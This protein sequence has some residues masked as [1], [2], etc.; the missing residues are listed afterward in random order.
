VNR[1]TLIS[2]ISLIFQ[3]LVSANNDSVLVNESTIILDFQQTKELFF[4]FAEGD[5][6]IFDLEMV[7]GKHIKEIEVTELPSN[8]IFSDFKVKEL[9]N[10]RIMI[11]NKGIYTFRFFSS[12]LTRRVCK[13]KIQRIPANESTRDF[14]TN[15]KWETIKDTIYTPY[16]IDSITGYNTVKYKERKRELV[17]SKKIEE[18]L[19][20]KSQRVHSFYNENSSYTYLRVDLPQPINTQFKEE[21]II[22][23]AYWIGVGKEAEQAF[24]QNVSAVSKLT[25]VAFGG[26]PLANFAIG[27]I[28]KL[29][30][31]QIGEDVSYYFLPDYN[32]LSLFMAQQNFSIFDQ[33]KGIAAYGRNTNRKFGTFYIGLHNDNK[34]IGINVNVKVV[35]IKEI[36]IYENKEYQ[37]EREEPI[38]VT[39]NKERM[40]VNETRIRV[41]VE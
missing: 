18:V 40:R 21:R 30:L 5:E 8:S 24:Q 34:M 1:I 32:N 6:I 29:I 3:P 16:T 13:I 7:K 37:R 9:K 27:T 10:K 11:R 33:G 17:S 4:S 20:D 12:S 19:F 25:Q 39:L 35:I 15:W 23:W 28:S 26:N 22:A 2:I 31:P 14:N 36:N 41:P 38:K